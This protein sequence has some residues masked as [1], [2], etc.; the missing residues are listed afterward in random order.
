MAAT[1]PLAETALIDLLRIRSV[2]WLLERFVETSGLGSGERI[3]AELAPPLWRADVESVPMTNAEASQ[4][5]ARFYL[6]DGGLNAFYLHNPLAPYPQGDPTGS[7]I[8]SNAVK[9]KSVGA[10]NKSLALKAL[11]AGYQL[12]IGDMVAV[13]HGSPTRRALFVLAASGVADGSGD[14]A[15]LEVRPHVRP[16]ILANAD[17]FLKHPSAK[18]KLLPDTLR[19][20]PL[21]TIHSVVRFSARQTLQAG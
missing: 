6:L 13:D 10:D 19:M 1:F 7:I 18:M 12:T 11:T 9:V 3:E 20:E 5:M 21:S 16:G 17:V 14:S 2:T 4:L 8:G 15:E